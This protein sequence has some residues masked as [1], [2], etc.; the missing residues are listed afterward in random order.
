MISRNSIFSVNESAADGVRGCGGDPEGSMPVHD[1]LSFAGG[2]ARGIVLHANG[3]DGHRALNQNIG[4]GQAVL[5]S[6]KYIKKLDHVQATCSLHAIERTL[7]SI[8]HG[9]NATKCDVLES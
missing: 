5:I 9:I 1:T 8:H 4:D 3:A 6:S 2:D 7:D